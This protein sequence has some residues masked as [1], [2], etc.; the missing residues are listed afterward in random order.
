MIESKISKWKKAVITAGLSDVLL[1]G[2]ATAGFAVS[3][4]ANAQASPTGTSTPATVTTTPRATVTA[5]AP[6]T[7]TGLANGGSSDTLPI[8]VLGGVVLA[9]GAAIAYA[10]SRKSS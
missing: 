2:L 10:A 3:T 4:Q 8:V 7:G 9:G 5:A 1:T 6:S